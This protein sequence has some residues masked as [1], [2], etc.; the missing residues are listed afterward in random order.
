MLG[1]E[2]YGEDAMTRAISALYWVL[3]ALIGG[4]VF[5]FGLSFDWFN[6]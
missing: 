1:H 2:L 4:Y 3:V 5:A 6:N